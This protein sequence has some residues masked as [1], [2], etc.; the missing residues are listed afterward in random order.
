MTGKER[1]M[2]TLGNDGVVN[3]TP[4]EILYVEDDPGDVILTKKAIAHAKV[5]N[6]LSV[7]KDGV[8]AL[9]MLKKKGAFADQPRPDLILLDLNM[10]RMDGRKFLEVVKSDA[11]LK[12]IPVVVLTTSDAEL[13]ILQSYKLQAS[14][15]ITKPVDLAQ[16]THVVRSIED[17]WFCLVRLPPKHS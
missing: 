16:F 7:A 14:C 4:I 11:D 10:P 6:N 17:F 8:E 2:M 12:A 13:D 15:F 3:V 5:K 1:G 9:E